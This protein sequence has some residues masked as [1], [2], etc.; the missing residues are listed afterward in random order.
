M[1][2]FWPDWLPW[3][4]SSAPSPLRRVPAGP[5]LPPP[6]TC[7]SLLLSYPPFP[8]W[9]PTKLWPLGAG[10]GSELSLIPL[11]KSQWEL[12]RG[13]C[14]VPDPFSQT[15]TTKPWGHDSVAHFMGRK[16]GLHVAKFVLCLSPWHLIQ[17]PQSLGPDTLRASFPAPT[18]PPQLVEGFL[19][20]FT[21]EKTRVLKWKQARVKRQ[22]ESG[23]P[24]RP[25][26]H[27][28]GLRG[29]TSQGSD[30]HGLKDPWDIC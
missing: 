15:L 14:V 7:L 11:L 28:R 26:L 30:H 24:F 12:R 21:G 16:W 5:H 19:P 22:W 20:P 29:L 13:T 1:R 4:R 18:S 9:V 10:S 6:P 23:I 25:H 17:R 2:R 3:P 8:A 27:H